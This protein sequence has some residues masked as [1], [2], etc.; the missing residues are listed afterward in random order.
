MITKYR[1][2]SVYDP[3]VEYGTLTATDGRVSK[4]D[5]SDGDEYGLIEKMAMGRRVEQASDILKT[6]A[7]EKIEEPDPQ[8]GDIVK[9]DPEK[10]LVFG[11]AY[12]THNKDGVQVVDKSGDFVDDVGEVETAAYDYVLKSRQGDADHTNLK[13]S[14]LVESVVFTKEKRERM[15]I[16]EGI[17]P[18]GWWIGFKIE[19]R[20]VWD[21]VKKGELTSFSVHGKGTRTEVVQ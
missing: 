14:D 9:I 4:F 5:P 3:D 12:V 16:P 18:D 10:Q 2:T 6:F 7:F 17:V 13:T 15:G 8:S 1:V 11:W 19:D 20:A 21:R